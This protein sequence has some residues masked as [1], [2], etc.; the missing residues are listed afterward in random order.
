MLL[1]GCRELC[2]YCHE[3]KCT[4]PLPHAEGEL[5]I[6]YREGCNK[7]VEAPR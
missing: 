4:L 2:D 3:D 7:R 1:T 6:C 5:H